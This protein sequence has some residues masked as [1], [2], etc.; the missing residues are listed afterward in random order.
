M[1]FG[2]PFILEYSN[3]VNGDDVFSV[4]AVSMDDYKKLANGE[5]ELNF[6]GRNVEV[7]GIEDKVFVL[8]SH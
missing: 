1:A 3:Y 4:I 7:N 8:I 5:A 6:D 2:M